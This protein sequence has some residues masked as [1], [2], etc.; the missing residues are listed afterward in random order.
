MQRPVAMSFTLFLHIRAVVPQEYTMYLYRVYEQLAFM[1]APYSVNAADYIAIIA[2]L[3]FVKEYIVW[4][5][6]KEVFQLLWLMLKD[7]VLSSEPDKSSSESDKSSSEPELSAPYPSQYT[8][9]DPVTPNMEGIIDL[10]HDLFYVLIWVSSYV[11]IFLYF[12]IKWYTNTTVYNYTK[13]K[14]P[15][16]FAHNTLLE[17][18]WTIIPGIVLLCV[19]LPS[20]ALLYAMDEIVHPGVTLKVIG[21]QWYWS[22]EYGDPFPQITDYNY[23]NIV[24]D[25]YL[26]NIERCP[27][28]CVVPQA[29]T[30]LELC[31]R[32]YSFLSG[33]PHLGFDSYMID[34][35]DL[36][37]GMF[38][39]LEVTKRVH[40]PE[41]IVVRVLVTSDDVLHS[42]A[43]PSC[44]V[45]MDAC[46][47]RLNQTSLHLERDGHYYGQCSELCG[48]GHAFMP[49]SIKSLDIVGYANWI[50]RYFS[51]RESQ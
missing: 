51:T 47:G 14:R 28:I 40:L 44:G 9:Q 29:T 19:A 18:V 41:D 23:N 25:C 30:K 38:R 32:K 24:Y 8:F 36:G 10:H 13:F 21:H 42:W 49:I 6:V 20:F 50:Y 17:I 27:K 48:V 31:Y 12:I 22:Y 15:I 2:F 33:S 45:K 46:P 11:F 7:Y 43:I 3:I 35:I 34:E 4:W 1:V 16:L 37:F 5:K 26:H 39:N